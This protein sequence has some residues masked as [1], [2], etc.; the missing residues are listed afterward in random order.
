MLAIARQ[1]A[2]RPIVCCSLRDI[3]VSRSGKQAEHDR[4]AATL[5]ARYFDAVLVHSDPA[6]AT[7]DESL[8]P[9][10]EIPVPVHHTG[11][12]H[13]SDDTC[14]TSR[15]AG[16]GA[17]VSAGGGLVGEPLLQAA[18]AAQSV[19][20]AKR[21]RR[22]T[23]VAGPFLPQAAW[24]SLR[25]LAAR[26]PA[27][28]IRRTVPNLAREMRRASMSISQCGYNT[29]MDLLRSA[30]PALVVP[31]GDGDE[32]EQLKRARRLEALG[33]LRVLPASELTPRRLADE[34][35]AL[36]TF[37]PRAPQLNLHGAERTAAIIDDML[38]LSAAAS[39]PAQEI[40]RHS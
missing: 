26:A 35:M 40:G 10:V 9:G 5:L 6:F 32:D 14:P 13:G 16:G 28:S 4:R 31:F 25:T 12:V 1:S 29:A 15:R 34:M 8:A 3:L 36:E 2:P 23:V 11:F 20:P 30:V 39:S 18:I 24:S 19:I 22:L 27:V 33:A 21:R 38:G 37:L 7:L 17:V